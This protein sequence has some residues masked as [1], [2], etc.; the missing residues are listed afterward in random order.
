MLML[1]LAG[2]RRNPDVYPKSNGKPLKDF[3]QGSDRA[4]AFGSVPCDRQSEVR[5]VVWKF[6][7]VVQGQEGRELDPEQF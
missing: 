6:S 2:H 5:R 7:I 3:K 4:G 1:G